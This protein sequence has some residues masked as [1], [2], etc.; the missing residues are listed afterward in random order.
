MGGWEGS[1]ISLRGCK[2]L[3]GHVGVPTT[4]CSDCSILEPQPKLRQY[5]TY[6]N[7]LLQSFLPSIQCVCLLLH[8]LLPTSRID[9]VSPL[10][11]SLVRLQGCSFPPRSSRSPTTHGSL[12]LSSSNL[13]V[14]SAFFLP[15]LASKTNRTHSTPCLLHQTLPSEALHHDAVSSPAHEV[16]L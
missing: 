5:E 11:H 3:L 12:A 2:P 1:S 4:H 10:P 15:P 16:F 14:T 9:S 13:A 7:I 6:F 8:I